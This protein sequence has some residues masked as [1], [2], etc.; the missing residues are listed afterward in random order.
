MILFLSGMQLDRLLKDLHVG[1]NPS[2]F[3]VYTLGFIRVMGVCALLNLAH[4]PNVVS[5]MK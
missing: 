5:Y 4:S 3:C 1:P 2:P